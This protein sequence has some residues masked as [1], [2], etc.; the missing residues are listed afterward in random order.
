[1][2]APVQ[3]HSVDLETV[4]ASGGDHDKA[5]DYIKTPCAPG[6]V[7]Y[8]NVSFQEL[9]EIRFIIIIASQMQ[10]LKQREAESFSNSHTASTR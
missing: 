4:F 9:Y 2:G 1:M 10:K 3:H 8:A 5:S 7:C 6:T